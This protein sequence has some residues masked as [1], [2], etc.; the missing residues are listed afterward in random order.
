[1]IT[2]PLTGETRTR[3]A[4]ELKRH[5]KLWT[6]RHRRFFDRAPEK[7]YTHAELLQRAERRVHGVRAGNHNGMHAVRS[8]GK[9]AA[10][11]LICLEHGIE[12]SPRKFRNLLKWLNR[13]HGP[14]PVPR[15]TPGGG[16]GR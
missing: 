7:T 15:H 4:S 12:Y 3:S 16:V 5:P 10:R 1:M 11:D 13:G 9:R 8:T 2:S 14:R 6:R